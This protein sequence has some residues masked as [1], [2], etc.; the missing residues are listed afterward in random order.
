MKEIILIFA[1]VFVLWAWI[2]LHARRVKEEKRM[3]KETKKTQEILL[4]RLKVKE[5]VRR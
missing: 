1:L 4:K 2:D 3:Q 5:S